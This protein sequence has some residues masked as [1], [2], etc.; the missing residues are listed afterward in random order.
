M[1]DWTGINLSDPFLLHKFNT[2]EILPLPSIQGDYLLAV[3][4]IGVLVASLS[5]SVGSLPL[6]MSFSLQKNVVIWRE[7]VSWQKTSSSMSMTLG[8]LRLQLLL[9]GLVLSV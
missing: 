4:V 8:P 9:T 1:I 7:F 2:S 3:L 6:S 5:G